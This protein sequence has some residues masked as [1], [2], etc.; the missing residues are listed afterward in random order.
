MSLL[1]VIVLTHNEE[2]HLERCLASIAGVAD[3]VVVVD[4]GSADRTVS[5]AKRLR[6]DVLVNPFINHAQQFNWALLNASLL[7][8][9]VM[10]L[11]ADEYIDSE[12]I[13]ELRGILEKADSDVVGFTLR[14]RRVFLGRWLKWG[15]L[16]PIRLTRIWRVGYGKCEERWM[17]EHVILDGKVV[18]LDLDF[19]DHNLN[20]LT[21]WTDKHNRYASREALVVL[22]HELN[23]LPFVSVEG[24]KFGSAS[25]K[26]WVKENLYFRLPGG[27]RAFLY[28]L[29][30]VIVRL[31]FLDGREGMIFHVLQ[32][33]WYR[34]L[35]DSKVYE[36]KR[37]MGAHG[38]DP[39]AAIKAVLGVDI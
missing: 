36:V 14:L 16:Y 10:K 11:D 32:G 17:D 21:W 6:A 25:V 7:T 33:F 12:L 2:I 20:S 30:R 23:F 3:R 18:D 29:Y 9:W 1:T 35:V 39:K 24:K 5:I 27:A 8:G 28:F 15:G 34:Y 38:D 13:K 19:S 31:G 37:Y 22:N 4:S 26:R